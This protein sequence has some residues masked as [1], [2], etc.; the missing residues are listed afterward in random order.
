MGGK[1]V[2]RLQIFFLMIQIKK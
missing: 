1:T 2:S